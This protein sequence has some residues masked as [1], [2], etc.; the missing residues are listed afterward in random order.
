MHQSRAPTLRATYR[1]Q[2]HAGFTLRD[3]T[4]VIP[5]LHALGISHVYAS[6]ILAARAGS[7]HGYDAT[8][9]RRINPELGSEDDLNTLAATLHERGMGLLVD[10]VP[11]HMA[12]GPENPYWEDVLSHGERSRY[13]KWFDIDWRM[14]ADHRVVLP[15]LRDELD[16]VIA[17]GELR[18]EVKE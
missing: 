8:D 5:Y 14:H 9:P 3:A 6:P 7:R 17:R 2:L 13:T 4:A 15:I 10:I 16:A 1:L 11:N 12:A 18:V